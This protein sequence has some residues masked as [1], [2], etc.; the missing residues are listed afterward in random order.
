[1]RFRR[2][3]RVDV[4]QRQRERAVSLSDAQRGLLVRAAFKRLM[5]PP[6]RN[7]HIY[8]FSSV[9]NARRLMEAFEDSR[10]SRNTVAV[11]LED[12]RREPGLKLR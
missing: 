7:D 3:K 12:L 9:E 6:S 1:M 2:G 5:R 8:L 4:N 11:D 10:T